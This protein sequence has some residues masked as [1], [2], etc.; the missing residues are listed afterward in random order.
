MALNPVRGREPIV[1]EHPDRSCAERRMGG[2]SHR[3]AMGFV[4]QA[5]QPYD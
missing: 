2:A 3:P 1:W 4:V 5:R